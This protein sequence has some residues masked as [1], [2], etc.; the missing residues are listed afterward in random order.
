MGNSIIA[1]LLIV[2]ARSSNC[3]IQI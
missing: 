1:I 2:V 3:H